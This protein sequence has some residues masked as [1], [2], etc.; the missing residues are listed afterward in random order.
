MRSKNNESSPNFFSGLVL[1]AI[2]GAGL[3]YYLTATEKGKK[4]GQQVK[5]KALEK[6][7]EALDGLNEL[8]GDIEQKG[9]EFRKKAQKVQARL[10]KKA[11]TMQTKADSEV[12]EQLTHIKKLQER[13]RQAAKF[14][15]RNGKALTPRR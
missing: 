1:G 9:E 15:T 5:Q 11:K 7:E 14:F 3:Y 6:G 8:V 10:E 2:L 4:V 13:G 12:K